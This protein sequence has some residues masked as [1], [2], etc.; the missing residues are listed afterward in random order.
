MESDVFSNISPLDHRYLVSDPKLHAE[1]SKYLSEAAFIKY[2][3]QV[4]SALT[5]VLSR[6]G[7]CPPEAADEVERACQ[8]ISPEEVYTEEQRTRH[9]IRALV[10]CI[11]RRVSEAARPYVHFTATSVDIMDTATALR[12]RDF[13]ENVLLPRE[14]ALLQTLIDLALR[15]KATCRWGGRMPAC[16]RSRSA[17]R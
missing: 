16:C 6:R 14:F 8:A 12:Y 4:E 5:R 1:L 7:I 2:E 3:L 17:M 10:N 11:Q 13:S 15:E 9:N